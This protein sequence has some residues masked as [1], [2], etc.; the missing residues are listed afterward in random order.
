MIKTVKLLLPVAAIL[1]YGASSAMAGEYIPPPTV[2]A[3]EPAT[4]LLLASGVGAIA[5]V[6]RFR[7]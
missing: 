3:P 7:K 4:M 1:L 6:R 5:M 2:L